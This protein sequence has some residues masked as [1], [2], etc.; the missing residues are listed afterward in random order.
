[1]GDLYS[2]HLE[3]EKKEVTQ[4][5]INIGDFV[6]STDNTK[7]YIVGKNNSKREFLGLKYK[8]IF[9]FNNSDILKDSVKLL[10]DDIRTKDSIDNIIC[11][12]SYLDHRNKVK[13]I[14]IYK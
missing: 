13:Q 6:T 9:N 5:N 8:E 11:S 4:E 10:L 14:L 7:Y 12:D 2:F 3:D 1:M